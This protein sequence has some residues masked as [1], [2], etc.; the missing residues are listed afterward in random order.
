MNFLIG[1]GFAKISHQL[2]DV[3]GELIDIGVSISAHCVGGRLIG[4]GGATE[5]K[6]DAIGVQG[7]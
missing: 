6:I 2:Y 5:A 7:L 1:V 4:A 3:L